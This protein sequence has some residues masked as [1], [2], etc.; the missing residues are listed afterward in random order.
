MIVKKN[1]WQA[2]VGEEE[3]PSV[4]SLCQMMLV[5]YWQGLT[6]QS[7]LFKTFSLDEE[8]SSGVQLVLMLHKYV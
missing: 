5:C 7:H 1:L 4:R 2:C 3:S 8:K 6:C